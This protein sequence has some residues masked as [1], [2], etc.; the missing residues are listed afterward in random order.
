MALITL[1]NG[2]KIQD[3]TKPYV[4]AEM[5][6]NH[7][8]SMEKVMEMIDCAKEAGCDCVKFQSWSSESL[9]SKIVYA[10]NPIAKRMVNKFALSENELLEACEYCNK[11]GI[12]L[13]RKSVV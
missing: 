4:V 13:D 3:F 2:R 8:G 1:R 9:Y 10:G 6:T 12:D 7:A 5:G 11:V